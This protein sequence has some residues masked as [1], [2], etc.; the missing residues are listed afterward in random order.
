MKKTLDLITENA[1]RDTLAARPPGK[2]IWK[3]S[4]F[5]HVKLASKNAVGDFGEWQFKHFS[6]SIGDAAQIIKKGHD[7]R[8]QSGKRVE[9]KTACQGKTGS[10]FFN[11]I[12]YTDPKT[13]IKKDWDHLVFVFV[14]PFC[15]EMWEC[16]QPAEPADHFRI[17]N[18]WSWR[19]NS[20]NKLDETIW[21]KI[22]ERAYE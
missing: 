1:I 15:V 13:N 12:Y 9:V 14:K 7:V 2:I 22:Y 18:G 19:R 21:T 10:F 6:D 20:S 5:L 16:K 3:G 8:T 11:Q 4:P 17:N